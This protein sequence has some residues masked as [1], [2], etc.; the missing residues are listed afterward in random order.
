MPCYLENNV[1][2]QRGEGV[3]DGSIRGLQRLNSLGYGHPESGLV[4]NLVYNPQGPSL[5]PP[6]ESL[7]ADYKRVL[8]ERYRVGFNR[9]YTLSNMPI[10]RSGA[11]LISKGGRDRYLELLR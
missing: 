5:P 6:Q 8:G 7:Q 3:F 11:V 4:L 2:A 1:D 10:P 9:L